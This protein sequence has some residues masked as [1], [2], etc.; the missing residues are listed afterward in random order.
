[1]QP[2]PAEILIEGLE[3]ECIIGTRDWERTTRQR[4]VLDLAV[5]TAIGP[6]ASSDDLSDALDYVELK[7]AVLAHV[8]AS[9]FR[10]IEALAE[11]VAVL[12]LANPRAA[13]V[14]VTLRKPGALTGARSVGVRIIRVRRGAA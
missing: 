4:V 9:R 12:V 2:C 11:S 6:A 7:E 14:T 1:M 10:L 13:A 5:A 3:V 8:Q